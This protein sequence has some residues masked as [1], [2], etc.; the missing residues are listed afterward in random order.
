LIF[1]IGLFVKGAGLTGV[2]VKVCSQ[3]IPNGFKEIFVRGIA[4]QNPF[5]YAMTRSV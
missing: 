3:I 4:G 1:Y 5:V 2:V